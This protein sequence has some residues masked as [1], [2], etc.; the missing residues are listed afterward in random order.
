[1]TDEGALLARALGFA[2]AGSLLWLQ[3]WDLKD[4]RRPEPRLRLLGAFLVGAASAPLAMGFYAAATA[5][6][7][8]ANPGRGTLAV[9]VFCIGL[10]GPV[11]EGA[12]FLL[13]R[14]VVFRWKVF[15]E[16]VD[17]FVYAAAVALGFAAVENL[18]YLPA[19]GLRDQIVR[20]LCAPLVHTL[21]AAAWGYGT[22]HALLDVRTRAGR[23]AWQAGT[24][25]L[26]AVLHG[27]Y[28]FV[29]YSGAS[30]ITVAVV[31]VILWAAVIG[32]ARHAV[33]RDAATQA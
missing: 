24:V 33:A 26:A 20:T 16:R 31:V 21:F 4:R 30:S 25:A 15:D 2:L 5:L 6:G 32:A 14:A 13:A 9:A 17:G 7:A 29:L 18:F 27:V 12:K 19:M 28:D 1:V 10:V 22:A 23:V 3:Y 11:E 8:P